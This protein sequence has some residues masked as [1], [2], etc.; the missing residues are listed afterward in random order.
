MWGTADWRQGRSSAVYVS[1]HW[2]TYYINVYICIYVLILLTYNISTVRTG[3]RSALLQSRWGNVQPR[4]RP[5][6]VT[7][8]CQYYHLTRQW[9][10][11]VS[12]YGGRWQGPYTH[13]HVCI[14]TCM[15]ACMCGVRINLSI[16]PSIHTYIRAYMHT[17]IHTCMHTYTRIYMHA[18]I[19]TY[20]HTYIHA[21]ILHV[22]THINT[23]MHTGLGFR[24]HTYMYM[25]I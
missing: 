15:N 22:H 13:V 25:H 18:C 24:G 12:V 20:I 19:H 5:V 17:Y 21:Y 1:L 16:H 11:W 8:H 2:H 6:W 3:G 7:A 4:I 14:C 9:L 23:C 10:R